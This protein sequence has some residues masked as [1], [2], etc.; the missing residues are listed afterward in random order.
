MSQTTDQPNMINQLIENIGVR[1]TQRVLEILGADR[2]F[3]MVELP[4]ARMLNAMVYR[5]ERNKL[6]GWT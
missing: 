1:N 3:T 2:M 4:P 6:E 5:A